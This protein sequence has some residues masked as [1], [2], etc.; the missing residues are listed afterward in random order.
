MD[1]F[2][3]DGKVAPVSAVEARLGPVG[4]PVDNAV[5]RLQWQPS[6]DASKATVRQLTRSLPVMGLDGGY[7]VW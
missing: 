3:L 1:R 2:R 7:T 6:S 5:N 4:V